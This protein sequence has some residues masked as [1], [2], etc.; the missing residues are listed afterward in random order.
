MSKEEREAF[1][2]KPNIGILGVEDPG[3]GPLTVPIWY[4]YE[5]GGDI[6]IL[7]GPGSKKAT[8]IANAQ[9]FSLCAQQEALPYRYVMAEGAVTETRPADLEE[10]E[11]PMARRYLGNL[12]GDRYCD[13]ATADS[14]VITMY[15]QR[16]YSV[17]Y[18]K[19]DNAKQGS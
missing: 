18:G 11:R 17:D 1:L 5:P 9:R 4:S 12:M 3:H 14:I 13:D 8:L 7:T 2:A 15:P 19:H 10:D 6:K 16:W